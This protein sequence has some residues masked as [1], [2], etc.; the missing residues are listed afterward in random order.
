MHPFRSLSCLRSAFPPSQHWPQALWV[1]KQPSFNLVKH[2]SLYAL[3][4]WVI[5]YQ[6][7]FFYFC[8]TM[9]WIVSFLESI[10]WSPNIQY[11]RMWLHL[12][13]ESFGGGGGHAKWLLT[14]YFPNRRWDPSLLHWKH[15]VLTTGSPG[16]FRQALFQRTMPGGAGLLPGLAHPVPA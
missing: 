11:L 12:E 6:W 5:M 10:C 4:W 14:S 15:N 7:H 3:N 16:K 2:Q 13:I 8:H 1:D 9:G